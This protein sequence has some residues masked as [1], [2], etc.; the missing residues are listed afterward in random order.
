MKNKKK[1]IAKI[2][3]YLF[4]L[5][6]MFAIINIII[7]YVEK[8][9]NAIIMKDIEQNITIIKDDKGNNKLKI[10][11]TDLKKINPDTIGYLEVNNTNINYIVVQAED[12]KFYLKNNFYKESNRHGWIFA[13]YRNTLNGNDKNIVIYGHNT[14]D[15]SMFGTL[16]R[17]IKE[18]WYTNEDNH[19]VTFNLNGEEKKYQV[20]SSYS[21]PV[22]DYYISTDFKD[23]NEF[24]E[25]L[26]TIKKRSVY[27]YNVELTENDHILTLSTC[28][29][30]GS[31][32]MVLHAKELR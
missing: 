30:N 3:T 26:N 16:R 14:R 19:I 29:G 28:T 2:I 7:W 23:N 24:K 31:K 9:N 11:F 4:A 25:F 15:G 13:D 17:V 5:G 10:N 20:F 6:I 27:N 18:N 21:I 1:T 12:N 32:R 22:E 8:N